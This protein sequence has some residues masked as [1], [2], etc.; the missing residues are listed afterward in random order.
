V[1]KIKIEVVYHLLQE[2]QE[3]QGLLFA[4]VETI[5]ALLMEL[6]SPSIQ[7]IS[8]AWKIFGISAVIM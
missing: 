5:K 4:L 7:L 2:L 3:D 6:N 8:I 1:F